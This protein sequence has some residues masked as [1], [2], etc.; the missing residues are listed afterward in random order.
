VRKKLILGAVGLAV[1]GSATFAAVGLGGS[2]DKVSV[3]PPREVEVERISAAKARAGGA[4]VSSAFVK[5]VKLNYYAA[6]APTAVPGNGAT[7]ILVLTCPVGKVVSGFYLTDR[8]IGVDHFA[9][10]PPQQWEFGFFDVSGVPG[11]ALPGIVCGK[12]IK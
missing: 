1:A 6:A 5:K 7:E 11:Q 3:G 9:A 12:G 2:D 8:L 4:Q 10:A